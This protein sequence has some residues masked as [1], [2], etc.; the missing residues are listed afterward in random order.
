MSFAML[1]QSGPTRRHTIEDDM[2]SLLYVVLYCAFLWLPHGLSEE[3]LATTMSMFF[4]FRDVVLGETYGGIG[5]ASNAVIRTYTR[6]VDFGASLREWVDSMMDL[7]WKTVDPLSTGYAVQP[8][9]KGSDPESATNLTPKRTWTLERVDE[10]WS[11][12]L[13]T[14]A[15]PSND[16]VTHN[17]PRSTGDYYAN[18][19]VAS[20][21]SYGQGSPR[22]Q[23][24]EGG[25]DDRG[26]VP[27][28]KRGRT[29]TLP[30]N[31]SKRVRPAS[32]SPRQSSPVPRRSQR[33]AKRNQNQA[34][35]TSTTTPPVPRVARRGRKTS[36][37]GSRK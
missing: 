29:S 18:V 11:T 27:S 13:Q 17:H 31:A 37:G 3:Q 2:E 6:S 4:E 30:A 14:H 33:I 7:R 10:Y 19:D 35:Q 9:D 36:G 26:R 21:P 5:K 34:R 32:P 8:I 1:E 20:C 28:R 12:F 22:K 15:L 16:R 24:T 25:I 23:V